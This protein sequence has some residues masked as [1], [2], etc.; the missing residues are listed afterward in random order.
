MKTNHNL[1]IIFLVIFGLLLGVMPLTASALSN[2]Q[3]GIEQASNQLKIK[4][5]QAGFTQDFKQITQFI[6]S[7]INPHVDFDHISAL[8]LG[9]HWRNATADEKIR[10]QQAFKTLLIRTYSRAF[11]QFKDWSVRYFDL[12]MDQGAEKV[13]VRTEILQPNLQP[14]SVNYRMHLVNGQWKAYDIIIEG[15]SLITNYRTSFKNEMARLNSLD[16]VIKSLVER[17]QAALL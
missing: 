11:I 13:I 9:Q 8:V 4:M 12:K 15:I 14:I 3:K 10:F 5:Q 16:S 6:E 1:N 7:E 2:P 17:N